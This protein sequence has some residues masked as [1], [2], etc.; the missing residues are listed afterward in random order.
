MKSQ[1]LVYLLSEVHINR[2]LNL[3]GEV[4][5]IWNLQTSGLQ[6]CKDNIFLNL[7]RVEN[8]FRSGSKNL[9]FFEELL[10]TSPK[11]S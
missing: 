10:P 8:N 9:N 1:S 5:S 7:D 6:E 3:E 4:H 2:I 11:S